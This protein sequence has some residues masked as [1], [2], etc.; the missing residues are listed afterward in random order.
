MLM[1]ATLLTT[2]C[3]AKKAVEPNAIPA[4]TRD[5]GVLV[6]TRADNGRAA[7]VRV[8]ERIE[9]RLPENPTTGFAWAIDETDSR[10]LAL[11]GTVYAAPTT[12]G[13]IGARGQRT[14]T[15]M[16]RQAS[17]IALKLKYWRFWE[18]DASVTERY[19]VTLRIVP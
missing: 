8:G 14:F 4:G 1:L 7:E 19:A 5:N 16:A 9:V 10:L 6:L 18:G 13:F 11:E 12:E 15:F 3:A 17:E 2:G